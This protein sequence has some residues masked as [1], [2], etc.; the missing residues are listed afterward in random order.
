MSKKETSSEKSGKST[1]KSASVTVDKEQLLDIQAAKLEKILE[2]VKSKKALDPEMIKTLEEIQKTQGTEKSGDVLDKILALQEAKR[3]GTLEEFFKAHE[4]K[5]SA[6][7][8]LIGLTDGQKRGIH[9]YMKEIV[10]CDE[11]IVIS[12]TQ[13]DDGLQTEVLTQMPKEMVEKI[14]G[15]IVKSSFDGKGQKDSIKP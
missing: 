6:Q 11:Y 1:K 13:F 3:S 5:R 7:Q 15:L 2:A 9:A 4:E 12:L 10:K 14:L 8:R